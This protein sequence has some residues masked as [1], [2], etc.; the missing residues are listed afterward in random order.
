MVALAWLYGPM[1]PMPE[2]MPISLRIGPFTT[3]IVANELVL[4]ERAV[5][6]LAAIA[7]ITGKYSGR[8]PAITALT[9]TFSTVNSQASRNAVGRRRPTTLSGDWLVPVSMRATR[10]SVGRT[11]GSMSVQRLRTKSS[12]R[13]SSV[14]G[15]SR[16]GVER[17]K[18]VP[19]TSSASS[20]RVRPST[21]S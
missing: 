13:F 11:T 9:A 2:S 10:S 1:T 12:C 18:L 15:S 19:F 8:A 6:P 16:R 3:D 5:C 7:R 21:T 14:S 4:L 17:S 20:A